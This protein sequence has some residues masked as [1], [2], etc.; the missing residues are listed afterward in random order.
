M[1]ALFSLLFLTIFSLQTAAQNVLETDTYSI[2]YNAFNST[3]IDSNAA[4]QNKLIRSKYTAMLN[5]A[6]H[7]K[8][9]DKSPKAVTSILTGS[10][11]NLVGQQQT[12]KFVKIKEGD[13]IYYIASF[14]FVD[15]EQM[16][17]TV[18]VQ[19]DPNKAPIKLTLSQKFYVD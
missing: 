2:H 4:Q 9:A 12:L 7:Q 13:A 11:E 15:Q 17:F 1:K 3:F 6:V 18:D 5:I 16:N 19:P 8:Q 14:K 10:V